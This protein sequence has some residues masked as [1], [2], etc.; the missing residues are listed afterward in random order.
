MSG[1]KKPGKA[2]DLRAREDHVRGLLWS[3]VAT[4]AYERAVL[5]V[6]RLAGSGSY[7]HH[8]DHHELRTIEADFAALEG[9]DA[10]MVA[11]LADRWNEGV[12][13]AIGAFRQ[14]AELHETPMP[15]STT[16]IVAQR[17]KARNLL[18]AI[19]DELRGR[20]GA[21]DSA[22]MRSLTVLP[23]VAVNAVQTMFE[24]IIADE[25]RST[26]NGLRPT[27]A[28]LTS[29]R[30]PYYGTL[31]GTHVS[32]GDTRP[33]APDLTLEQQE[34]AAD[35][36]LSLDDATAQ[37]VAYLLANWV[38]Q[39]SGREVPLSARVHVND[40]LAFRERARHHSG[41][42][43][44]EE[45]RAERDRIMRASEL[46]I[47]VREMVVPRGGKRA[48]KAVD[49]HSHLFNLAIET[50]ADRKGAQLSMLHEGVPSE[51]IPYAFRYSPGDWVNSYWGNSRYFGSLFAKVLCYDTRVVAERIAMRLAL[52]LSF[53]RKPGTVADLLRGARIP[54]PDDH[55]G[56][57]RGD[58]ED[59]LG[60]LRDDGA[61]AGFEYVGG[62]PPSEKQGWVK[63]WLETEIVIRHTPPSAAI[64]AAPVAIEAE[65]GP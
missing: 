26:W 65:K 35:T 34:A 38:V 6:A 46:W 39:N 36:V 11:A 2:P 5:V 54:V 3:G 8:E 14:E 10:R 33:G 22:T 9:D 45:K 20:S 7:P 37:T 28:G 21:F 27:G 61:I 50:E 58:V 60:R 31:N 1:P 32:I 12:G 40:L 53:E 4:N 41:D 13:A 24:A 42:Y 18:A 64:G 63:A 43:R 30:A 52:Y 55:R 57:F 19:S 44:P 62:E 25:K 49:V 15:S 48:T 29:S 16:R 56:R 59:A 23:A 17:E 51:S 47:R